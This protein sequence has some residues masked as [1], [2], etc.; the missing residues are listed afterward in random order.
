MVDK[1]IRLNGLIAFK[2]RPEHPDGLKPG[3]TMTR[4]HNHGDMAIE[5]KKSKDQQIVV[6]IDGLF[7]RRIELSGPLPKLETDHLDIAIQW[8]MPSVS[9][10]IGRELVA[11]DCGMKSPEEHTPG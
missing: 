1:T 4:L 7:D 2:L 11:S 9:L 10:F 6:R 5:V 8:H 3:F